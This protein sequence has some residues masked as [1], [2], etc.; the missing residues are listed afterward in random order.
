MGNESEALQSKIVV[1]TD[2]TETG[3]NALREA[4]RLARHSERSELHVTYVIRAERDM[5]DAKRVAELSSQLRTK[6]DEL[7]SRVASVCA[8]LPSAEPF[9]R[10]VVLHVRLGHPAEALHQVA[11][12]VDA[13]MIVV[14][15]HGRKGVERLILGS[16][17]EE[18]MRMA[19][20]PVVVAHPKNFGGLAKSARAEPARASGDTDGSG[21]S[22]RVRIEFRP[23]TSHIA[24]LV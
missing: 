18:L 4:M 16:V 10:D 1:G 8:P 24:G 12:D 23:R 7:Q 15:T 6:F 19:R 20:L 9:S 17:A 14:G 11:V 21:L 3:D 2:L 5:H 22:N 13:D